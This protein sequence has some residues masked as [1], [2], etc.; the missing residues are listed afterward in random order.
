MPK[1]QLL[2]EEW[3]GCSERFYQHLTNPDAD[4]HS[5]PSLRPGTPMEELGEG[6]KELKGIVTP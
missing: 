3:Y 5:Q 6:L 1:N 4:I 2:R